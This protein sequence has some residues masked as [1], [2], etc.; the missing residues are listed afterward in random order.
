MAQKKKNPNAVALGGLGGRARAKSLS[1]TERSEIAS[2]A[3]KA[4]SEKLSASRRS[5]IAKRA[6][7]AREAKKKGGKL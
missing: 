7:T 2:K 4:R 3:A 5:E 6:V 1:D